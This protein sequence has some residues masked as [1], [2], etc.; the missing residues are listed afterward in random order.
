MASAV[1]ASSTPVPMERAC[2]AAPVF[3]PTPEEFS[4][5]LKYLAS[6]REVAEA[7]G[8]CRIVP[9]DGWDVPLALSRSTS[10]PVSVQTVTELHQRLRSGRSVQWRAE[11]QAFLQSC[12]EKPVKQPVWGG[13]PLDLWALYDAVS[14]RGG[15]TVVCGAGGWK[16]VARS[17]QAME[18]SVVLTPSTAS[19]SL[20]TAY[21]KHLIHYELYAMAGE[22]PTVPSLE[23]KLEEK[24]GSR[25]TRDAAAQP[26]SEE[27][28]IAS[29]MLLELE[30]S[31]PGQEPSS[32]AVAEVDEVSI[33]I[34]RRSPRPT[35]WA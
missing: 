12:G 23:A 19:L 10:F 27:E 22:L 8:I 34:S 31:M 28:V 29:A 16:E 35:V 30:K 25:E 18:P 3:R 21:E 5:P 6:I 26:T 17:L 33:E 1:P 11:Y 7:A 13:K 20:R 9:P 2:K 15:Y 32:P 4:D 24:G 14:R